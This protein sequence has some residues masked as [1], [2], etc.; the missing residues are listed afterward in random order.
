MTGTP[1]AMIGDASYASLAAAIEAAKDGDTIVLQKDDDVSFSAENLEL[2][3]NKAVTIDGNGHV[4]Y[5]LNDYAGGSGDHD[6]FISGTTNVT[7]RNIT[8]A[9]FGGAVPVT[10]RTYPIWTG[11][12]YAGTLTLDHVTVTNFNRTAFNLNGGTVLVKNCTIAGDMEKG[13]QGGV[14]QEGIEAYNA[15]VTVENTTITGAGST[16]ER[17]DSQV[18]AC[19]QLGN[20]NGPTPGT[21]SILVKS[22]TFAG[23]YGII[24][25]SNAV[26]DVTVQG[27]AFSGA[28]MVED[29]GEGGSIAVSGGTFD[30]PVPAEFA[31]GGYVPT[32]VAD[33]DGKYTVKTACTVS[34][35]VDDEP[36]TNIVVASGETVPQPAD[37]VSD[38][39]VFT[40]WTHN[41]SAYD[42]A[43]PVTADIELEAAITSLEAATWIGGATNDWNLAANWDIGYVPTKDTVVTFTN[44]AE[45]AIFSNTNR[46][47]ELV[48]ANAN[49]TLVRDANATQPVLH[50]YGNGGSAVSVASGATGSLGASGI[51]LFTEST[52]D[53]DLTIG[54][55]LVILGDVT[56]RGISIEANRRSASFAI[57]GKTT[58][59]A[60]ATVKTIDW[61]NTK[62]RGGIEVARG[63]TAKI[64]TR[65]NGRAQI[66]TGVTLVANPGGANPTKIWLMNGSNWSR[67]VS[68]DDGTSVAVDPDHA[69][70]YYV[71]ME[72]DSASVTDEHGLNPAYCDVYTAS[73]KRTVVS[74]TAT[75][76][77]VT[78]VVTGQRVAPGETIAIG[79]TNLVEGSEAVLVITKHSDGSELVNTNALP[80]AYTMPDFDIDVSVTATAVAGE[81]EPIDLSTE[82]FSADEIAAG[83]IP[84]GVVTDETSGETEFIVCFHGQGGV[85]YTLQGST[86]LDPAD[87]TS[88]TLVV[89]T[90][91]RCAKDGDLVKLEFPMD[92]ENVPDAMFFTIG[93]SR[94][95][96][97]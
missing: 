76:A 85:T 29:D 48:L 63:V 54:C 49:V 12:A 7:I 69:A 30:V 15:N 34:F 50:I 86:T 74:V 21:G 51:S 70:T 36:Y 10:G 94:T 73:P 82:T 89:G 6:I 92:G 40:G 8:L 72:P 25:A 81:P 28:L 14:F 2:V 79:T 71:K 78:G 5:G 83:A 33:N 62:F 96:A 95:P 22:G 39:Y 55:D 23:E 58:V 4:L 90:P 60:N 59:S 93:A 16:I 80:Y 77:T 53:G 20:P 66:G 35:T 27:G 97:P 38:A 37:P 13:F 42:F 75:N 47:K 3:V 9:G 46:C 64:L 18:A 67:K 11:S 68:L 56:F 32:T 61:G 43:A 87:W 91:V 84:A 41:G 1:V 44:D 31:A 45:V 88:E 65:P 17:E 57:T 24:V 26:N 52:G 19:I